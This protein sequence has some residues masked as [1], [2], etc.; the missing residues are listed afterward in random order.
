MGCDSP[1]LSR[2]CR[3]ARAGGPDWS[4]CAAACE[5]F[6]FKSTGGTRLMLADALRRLHSADPDGTVLMNTSMYPSI[7]PNA[8]MTYRQTINESDKQ[9]YWAALGAPAAHVAIVLAFAG[10]DIDKAVHTHPE[11]L[12]V[13]QRF[14]SPYKGWD[15]LD[16]TIY[17]ADTFP[18]AQPTP[19]STAVMGR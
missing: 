19:S 15:Q 5:D 2:A 17:V 18:A 1:V 8:G 6:G 10:D 7:V 9:Y 12:R 4:R 16:A 3:T 11:H 14:H 13:Y